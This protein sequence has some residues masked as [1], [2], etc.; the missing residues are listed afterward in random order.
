MTEAVILLDD[1]REYPNPHPELFPAATHLRLVNVKMEVSRPDDGRDGWLELWFAPGYL[2][3]DNLFFELPG[4]P[5]D[6][7]R[8]EEP[9]VIP[10]FD[11]ETQR[12]P[13]LL[14]ITKTLSQGAIDLGYIDGTVVIINE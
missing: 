14:E 9:D 1:P 6:N 7:I 10:M 11:I 13:L 8:L 12:N 5:G 4:F 2:S 3:S